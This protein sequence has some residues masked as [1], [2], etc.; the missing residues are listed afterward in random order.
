STAG[1]EFPYADSVNN[2]P[3]I[4]FYA[5]DP[6][7]ANAA[8]EGLVFTPNPNYN[9]PVYF[10]VMVQDLT[11]SSYY[12]AQ[13]SAYVPIPVT[14]VNDAP[15][16]AGD[17]YQA[18]EAQTFTAYGMGVLSNDSDPER[19][20]LS[21]V[22]VSGP[23]HGTVSLSPGGGFTY[24]PAPN[25]NG[26][27][28]FTY[29]PRDPRGLLSAPATLSP[30]IWPRDD[31]PHCAGP[32]SPDHCRGHFADV[33]HGQQQGHHGHR[34]RVAAAAGSPAGAERHLDLGYYHWARVPRPR[35][36]KQQR[37]RHLLRRQPGRGQRRPGRT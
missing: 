1:L 22:L 19:D 8:L 29:P 3:H 18:Y 20:M 14:P 4:T 36:P 15:V 2:S 11:A 21:A 7:E 25:Y 35:K 9:G 28:S 17:S 31:P 16:P 26:P 13:V 30:H 5:D 23:A 12:P 33:L 32:R 6:A 34:Y 10:N 27:D 37:P 24:T